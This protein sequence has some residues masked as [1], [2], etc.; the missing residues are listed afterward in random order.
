MPSQLKLMCDHVV[1]FAS[2]Y[3]EIINI[4]TFACDFIQSRN[5]FD[6]SLADQ[7]QKRAYPLWDK[8]NTTKARDVVTRDRIVHSNKRC[9]ELWIYD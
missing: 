6:Q 7:F 4:W 3:H 1:H 8:V 2:K 5:R 9:T